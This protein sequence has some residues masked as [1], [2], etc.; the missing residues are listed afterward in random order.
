[1]DRSPLKAIPNAN[2]VNGHSTC[3]PLLNN[4]TIKL[5]RANSIIRRRRF[6]SRHNSYNSECVYFFS[7]KSARG[8]ILAREFLEAVRRSWRALISPL[9]TFMAHERLM[10]S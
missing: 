9:R 1:M 8:N 2:S 7:M 6:N 5:S 4:F 3:A 10:E